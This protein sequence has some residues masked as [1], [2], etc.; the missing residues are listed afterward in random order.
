MYV[1]MLC[2]RRQDLENDD[3]E[4]IWL[5]LCPKSSQTFLVDH[6]YRNH[7]STISWNE[8]FDDQLEQIM[9]EDKE[10]FIL[11]NFNRDLMN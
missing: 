9:D 6:F 11:E 10:V 5:E 4:S 2:N 7:Q 8:A 3:F 1:K